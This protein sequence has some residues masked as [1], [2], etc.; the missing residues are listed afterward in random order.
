MV[1]QLL[2]ILL[3][4]LNKLLLDMVLL[5][6]NAEHFAQLARRWASE[7][8]QH[9]GILISEQYRRR[10]IGEFLRLLLRFLDTV[11]AKEMRNGFRYLSEF[12]S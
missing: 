6:N 4:K 11:S 2:N 3:V 12:R 1:C 5:T 7:G 10:Q 8:R 9:A